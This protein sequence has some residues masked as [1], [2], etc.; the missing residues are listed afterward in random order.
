[1][2]QQTVYIVLITGTNDADPIAE[3]FYH[4]EEA[5]SFSAGLDGKCQIIER[6]L[7]LNQLFYPLFTFI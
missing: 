3:V 1:M 4:Q 5:I 6:S 7:P 2:K